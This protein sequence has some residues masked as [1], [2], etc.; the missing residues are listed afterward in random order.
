MTVPNRRMAPG[1]KPDLT[2]HRT[3]KTPDTRPD[4]A[5]AAS[6]ARQAEEPA[7]ITGRNAISDAPPSETAARR[8]AGT[9]APASYRLWAYGVAFT[10]VLAM[11]GWGLAQLPGFNRAGPLAC[12]IGVAVAYRHFRGYPEPLRA[13]I[14]F[15]SKTLLRLAIV[16]FGLKLNIDVVLNEGLGLLVRDAA[17]IAFAIALTVWIG[18][19]LKADSALTLLVGIGTGICGAA[20]IAAVS[21]IMNAKDEDTAIGAGMIALVGTLFAVAYTLLMPLLPLTPDQY[22]AWAGVSLHE[23]AH[24]ALAAEPGGANAL[25]TGLL[26]KLGRVFLLVPL[27]LLLIGWKKRS[28]TFQSGTKVEFPWFM[29]GFI[30]MSVIG[31]YVLGDYI[32]VSASVLDGV[33]VVTTVLLSMAMVGLGLN[34]NLKQLRTKALK[35][36]LAMTVTSVLLSILT[37]LTI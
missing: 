20:A 28:G 25:A 21:P 33:S 16:L 29:V 23:I 24:V 31:S 14:R 36:L 34:V 5:E 22:G 8:H 37:Y 4:A 13:G 18:K 10:F 7:K 1:V 27:C 32:P 12:A 2:Y 11:L 3:D 17:T 30:A 35:P 19:R 15:S 9:T 6:Y 26:A